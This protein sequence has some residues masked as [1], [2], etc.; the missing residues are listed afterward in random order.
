MA[1]RRGGLG[2]GLDALIGP[3]AGG[4][5]AGAG[6][7]WEPAGPVGTGFEAET[8]GD[9]GLR[10]VEIGRIE[11]NPRQP[12][13]QMADDELEALAGSIAEHGLLQPLVVTE[14][15]PAAPGV[16]PQGTGQAPRYQ[17]IAGERRWQA[18]KR[19]GLVRVPVVVRAASAREQLE[20][21][22][23][24]NV[25]RA[26]LNP[27]EEAAA[28]QQLAE[29]FGL[30][31]EDIG[32]RV[33]KSRFAINNTL[34]LLDLPAA[35]QRALLDRSITE[36]HGR[37]LAGLHDAE[38]QIELLQRIVAERLSVRQAEE[39]VRRVQEPPPGAGRARRTPDVDE[40]Q[41]RFQQALGTK[42]GLTRGRR[43]GKL[44]IHFYDDE[45]LESLYERL[46]AE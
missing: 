8:G 33:G 14:L 29:E 9:G 27:L 22:L 5:P 12:R 6:S 13:R 16:S 25:Q 18:A 36:G 20:L 21:A 10:Q 42:V 24:E 2:R 3:G 46:V 31:Q 41:E 40:L 39:L 38:Q 34:R 7:G 23:V 19:A 17:L 43:G 32:R 1:G 44:V 4:G 30:T 15:L 11:P 28:Y 37:A 35:V 26:D 45:Q